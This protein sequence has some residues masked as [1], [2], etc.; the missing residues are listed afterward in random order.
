MGGNRIWKALKWFSR[1]IE[2][3]RTQGVEGEIRQQERKLINLKN[4]RYINKQNK[5]TI[6]KEMT[7]RKGKGKKKEEE[8]RR[9]KQVLSRIELRTFFMPGCFITTTPRETHCQDVDNTLLK[10]FPENFPQCPL[11]K[12]D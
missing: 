1:P 7:K 3:L 2:W 10:A 9:G 5:I 11:Y 8:K 6:T 12:G 4:L